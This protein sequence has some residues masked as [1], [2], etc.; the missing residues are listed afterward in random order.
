M[1]S[2]R[3]AARL[4]A[5]PTA[6]RVD[7]S[8]MRTEHAVPVDGQT[9]AAVHH[10]AE[11]DRWLLFCHGFLSDKSGSYESRC[12]RAVEEGYNAVR[13]DFRGSGD[14]DGRFVESTL[15][16]RIADLRAIVE[17]FSPPSYALFGSSFGAKTALHAAADAARLEALVARS[18]VTYNRAFDAYRRTVEREGIVR[19]DADRA[20]D[21]RFFSDFDAYEFD[22]VRDDVDVPIAIFH[23]AADA[24]VPIEDSFEAAAALSTD[25]SLSKYAGEGHRFSEGGERRLREQAF[26]WLGTVYGRDV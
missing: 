16:S 1:D 7:T 8:P 23:G 6:G 2:R 14:S 5:R 20:I 10:P 3:R 21:E 22:S 4:D 26:G 11:S 18:P 19:Y 15:S 17:Y 9:V 24:S 12:E 13:F 25:V